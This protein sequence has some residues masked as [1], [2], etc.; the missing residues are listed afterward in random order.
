MFREV[1]VPILLPVI[2]TFLCIHLEIT[3]PAVGCA[4]FTAIFMK[5]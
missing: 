5:E 3:E 4:I 2:N 1:I